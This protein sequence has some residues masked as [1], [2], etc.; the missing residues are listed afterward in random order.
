VQFGRG[1]RVPAGKK[2][3][4]IL[5]EHRRARVCVCVGCTIHLNQSCLRCI[6]CKLHVTFTHPPPKHTC[7]NGRLLIR[8]VPADP[9]TSHHHTLRSSNAIISNPLTCL[10]HPPP[11][12]TV[13][14][15]VFL[16]CDWVMT[17]QPSVSCAQK[18]HVCVYA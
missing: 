9:H 1:A 5:Q 8:H 3:I 2:L 6:G 12:C 7:S 11:P 13:W 10:V 16:L 15:T 18:T 4:R 14:T 17:T